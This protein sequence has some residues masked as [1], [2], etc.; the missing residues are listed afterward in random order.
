MPGF[1]PDER[2]TLALGQLER[3]NEDGLGGFVA[4][5]ANA[6]RIRGRAGRYGGWAAGEWSGAKSSPPGSG[7]ATRATGA[8]CFLASKRSLR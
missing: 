6:L 4:A 1:A 5:H 7:P 8:A 2:F 3:A